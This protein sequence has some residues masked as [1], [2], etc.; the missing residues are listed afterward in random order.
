MDF[1]TLAPSVARVRGYAAG[2]DGTRLQVTEDPGDV[3]AATEWPATESAG[4]EGWSAEEARVTR[5]PAGDTVWM[6]AVAAA[7]QGDTAAVAEGEWVE[8]AVPAAPKELPLLTVADSRPE[9]WS[10]TAVFL[11]PVLQSDGTWITL[12][13]RAGRYL[14]WF[15]APAGFLMPSANLAPD[16]Q[17]VVYTL[18]DYTYAHPDAGVHRLR[19]DGAAADFTPAPR[20]H[21]DA[22]WVDADTVAWL[23]HE[24]REQVGDDGVTR[25]WANDVL[26]EAAAGAEAGSGTR[27]YS[28]VDDWGRALAPGCNHSDETPYGDGALD[29]THTNSLVYAD[30][31]YFLLAH[32]L[33]ALV[34]VPRAGGIAWQLGGPL[35]EFVDVAGD[36]PDADEPW[37]VDGP[38]GTWWS[39]GHTSDVDG[40]G[41]AVF[42]NGFHH[43]RLASRAVV[44]AV[45]LNQRTLERTF[46]FVSESGS[47]SPALGDVKRLDGGN[48]LVTWSL[49]GMVT[50]L[51][52]EGEVVWRLSSELGSAL[53]RTQPVE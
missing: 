19:M 25:A 26:V 53:M 13:D 33:D 21:H 35:N 52:P 42:D 20:V 38:A 7:G 40:D 17:T 45:D 5:L 4:E 48:V 43:E 44:Y 22:T 29:V 31:T 51:T 34:A 23:E 46:E 37:K 41:F 10:G 2:H 30:D 3:A 14:W 24:S 1:D 11:Q 6:R 18:N 12:V 39:H 9:A 27:V 47:L 36:V 8:V 50:E 15:E 28:W 49:E 32:H 16:G